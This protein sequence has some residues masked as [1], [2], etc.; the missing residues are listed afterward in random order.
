MKRPQVI[1]TGATGFV[2]QHLIPLL[3]KNGYEVIALG[4]DEN[5][6]KLFDWYEKVEFVSLDYHVAKT[7]FKPKPGAGLIHLAWHGLPNYM[8]LFHYEENLPKNYEFIKGLVD[9]SVSKVLAVGTCFEYGN[10]SGPLPTSKL[11]KPNNPYALAK[12]C[13]RKQLSSLQVQTGFTFQWARLFY[14]YGKG[15]NPK[16]IL[17]QLDTAIQNGDPTFNM[18]GGEQLRDYLP[19]E[20]VALQLLAIF[21]K[22]DGGVFNVCSGVPISIRRLVENRIREKGATIK[23][24]L[25]YYPYPEF[26]PMAFW[27]EK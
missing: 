15:Q 20:E 24:N 4:R 21:E 22:N 2:G 5:K 17:A 25:G 3:L 8:S 13:L 26:E 11:A 1:V 18:S 16:S 12:D 7:S 14:M 6:A 9:S 10:Q 23:M 19:V 27:G